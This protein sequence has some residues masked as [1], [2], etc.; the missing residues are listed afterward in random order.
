MTSSSKNTLAHVSRSSSPNLA[1]VSNAAVT[2]ANKCR[3]LSPVHASNNRRSSA[4]VNI[5]SRGLGSS[6][7]LTVSRL[8]KRIDDKPLTHSGF[9]KNRTK[10][11]QFTIDSSNVYFSTTFRLRPQTMIPITTVRIPV[12]VSSD[13]GANV[14]K[15]PAQR[16]QRY[17]SS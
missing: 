11:G 13:S 6:N 10:R 14:R 5:R 15:I 12:I 1:P 8:T 17:G 4:A 2:N 16:E 7:Q 3:R 9:I